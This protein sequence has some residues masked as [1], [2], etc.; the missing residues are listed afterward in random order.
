MGLPD[1][2]NCVE[3]RCIVSEIEAFQKRQV[4]ASRQAAGAHTQVCPL[5]KKE[6]RSVLRAP[7]VIIDICSA[8]ADWHGSASV[9]GD[10]EGKEVADRDSI[11]SI[12]LWCGGELQFRS[13]SKFY[14]SS[15]PCMKFPK[16]RHVIL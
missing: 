3:L 12:C 2:E 5:F 9:S 8:C 7:L 4:S 16:L 14:F 11:M 10:E 13:F 6:L 1:S 15:I